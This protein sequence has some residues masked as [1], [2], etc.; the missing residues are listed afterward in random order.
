MAG[1][2]PLTRE[3]RV[4]DCPGFREVVP[5][6]DVANEPGNLQT[7]SR[8]WLDWVGVIVTDGE[9]QSKV[10]ERQSV[11]RSSPADD[12]I[13]HRQPCHREPLPQWIIVVGVVDCA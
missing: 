3:S 12:V 11:F 4:D 8:R 5:D 1:D 7:A 6:D 2:G 13:E 9:S 10:D